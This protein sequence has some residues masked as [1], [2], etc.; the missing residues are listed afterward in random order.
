MT[1]KDNEAAKEM[2][3]IEAHRSRIDNA[4]GSVEFGR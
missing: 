3:K 4:E 1:N 2:S